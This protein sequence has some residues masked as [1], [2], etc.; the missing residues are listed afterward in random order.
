M[1]T[2]IKLAILIILIILLIPLFVNHFYKV[3]FIFHNYRVEMTFGIFT[4]ILFCCFLLF[5]YFIRFWLVI[6]SIFNNKHSQN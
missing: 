2:I 6:N 1:K 4:L 5:Y 3:I